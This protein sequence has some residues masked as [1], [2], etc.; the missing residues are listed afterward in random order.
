MSRDLRIEIADTPELRRL[1]WTAI[2]TEGLERL[3]L[4]H[5]L[6][7][8][9]L[10]WLDNVNPMHCVLFN[11][12]DAASG[13]FIGATWVS[14]ILG[15]AGCMHFFIRAPFRPEGVELA[16]VAITAVFE[17]LNL[18]CVWGFTPAPYRHVFGMLRALG[19]EL[20]G[21]LHGACHMPTERRPDRYVDG[22]FTKLIPER[23]APVGR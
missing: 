12:W 13:E 5:R 9:V 15:R 8:T 19:F 20:I 14:P 23:L 1:P 7:P 18:A 2:Q 11:V 17:R 10:D 4:W 22:V 3:M 21:R 16:R 6:R